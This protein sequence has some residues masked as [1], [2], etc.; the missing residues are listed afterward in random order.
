MIDWMYETLADPGLGRG[1][2]AEIRPWFADTVIFFALKNSH[3]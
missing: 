3:M 2:Q 1:S